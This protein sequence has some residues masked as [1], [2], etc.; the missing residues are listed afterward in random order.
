[1]RLPSGDQAAP[2]S[3]CA[4]A[5]VPA[6]TRR[7]TGEAIEATSMKERLSD[8]SR[9]RILSTHATLVPSGEIA[10][11]RKPRTCSSASSTESR[12]DR[13]GAAA[14]SSTAASTGAIRRAPVF[15]RRPVYDEAGLTQDSLSCSPC[16]RGGPRAR[17]SLTNARRRRDRHALLTPQRRRRLD[18]RH[19]GQ[20]TRVVRRGSCGEAFRSLRVG[21]SRR[22]GRGEPLPYGTRG[23]NLAR[24]TGEPAVDD[25]LVGDIALAE[26]ALEPR[27]LDENHEEVEDEEKYQSKDHD[28]RRS[29]PE[30]VSPQDQSG[31]DVHRVTHVPVGTRRNESQRRVEGG[32]RALPSE[33]EVPEAGEDEDRPGDHEE[34]PDRLPRR[35]QR[36]VETRVVTADPGS[37]PSPKEHEA[38]SVES[39]PD[40]NENGLHCCLPLESSPESRVPPYVR[41]THTLLTCVYSSSA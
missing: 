24:R 2:C 14:R 4:R 32:G 18:G 17:P 8:P 22:G 11:P 28:G 21:G 15:M 37:E 9:P 12:V 23:S 7:G 38:N 16:R 13:G 10:A 36:N 31:P 19:E 34:H 33:E 20:E 6:V 40:G 29:L 41:S 25:P 26:A 35:G 30:T 3:R 5:S 39:G 1:M 27:L